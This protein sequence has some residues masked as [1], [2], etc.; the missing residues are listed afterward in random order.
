MQEHYP[1]A[2]EGLNRTLFRGQRLL[3]SEAILKLL[4]NKDPVRVVRHFVS[5]F[6]Q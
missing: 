3:S 6:C 5:D 1:I 2:K 4:I